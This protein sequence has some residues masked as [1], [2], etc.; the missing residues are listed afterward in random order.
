M[1]DRDGT[2]IME[3]HYLAEP[4]GVELIHGAAEALRRL[5]SIGLE[6]IVVTNQAGI[7]RGIFAEEQLILIHERMKFLLRAEGVELKGIYYC[8]HK[9]D[10]R[11]MCRK[12]RPGLVPK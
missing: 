11:C 4:H 7:G 12:P 2:I 8:P 1:L 6:L 3:R 10:D 5:S 9:P